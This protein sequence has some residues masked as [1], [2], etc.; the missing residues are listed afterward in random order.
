LE[1]P[2]V[3]VEIFTTKKTVELRM[4]IVEKHFFAGIFSIFHMKRGVPGGK[5]RVK[6]IC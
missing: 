3:S 5:N 4:K 2:P 6:K 1:K